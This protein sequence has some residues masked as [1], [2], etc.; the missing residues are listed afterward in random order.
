MA[1]E[2]EIRAAAF[3]FLDR[4]QIFRR[5]GVPR[6]L[7]E[8]GF[9]FHGARVALLGPKGIFKTQIL[10]DVPLSINTVPVVDGRDRP[11]DDELAGDDLLQYRYRGTDPGHPDNAG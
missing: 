1:V 11:Y 5:D 3:I 7:L 9:E 4:L 6:R 10:K 8:R 2:D